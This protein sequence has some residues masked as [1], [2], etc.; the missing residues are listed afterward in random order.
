MYEHVYIVH[1]YVVHIP[2]N[3]KAF[4]VHMQIFESKSDNKF[5]LFAITFQLSKY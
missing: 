3:V 5:M 4:M 2:I 1:T